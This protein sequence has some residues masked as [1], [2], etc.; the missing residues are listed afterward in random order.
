MFRHLYLLLPVVLSAI[1]LGDELPVSPANGLIRQLQESNFDEVVFAARGSN[2]TDGHWYAN[3]GY[4][5]EDDQ[6]KAYV[7]GSLLA[8]LNIHTG[9]TTVLLQ[10]ATGTIRDP[11][12]DY[13]GKTIVF[14]YRQG[15]TVFFNLYEIQSDGT[16]LRQ[17]TH[18]EYDDIEPCL[19]PDGGIVFVSSRCQRWVN[20]WLTQVAN[21]HRSNRDGSNIRMISANI[22]HDN[23][24]WVLPDGRILH[25]RWEYVDRNQISFHHLWTSN[26]DGTN[27]MVYFGNMHPEGLY[28]DAKPIPGTDRVVMINSPGHGRKDHTGTVAIVTD[29]NGPD[30]LSM[31][32]DIT[33]AND[34]CDPFPVSADLF[35]AARK[36]KMVLLDRDG[37]EETLYQQQ[38]IPAGKDLELAT[39]GLHEPRPLMAR[40]RE[41]MISS[42]VDLGKATG[43]LI[44]TD[45][46]NGRN[47][48]GVEPGSIKELLVVETLPKPINYTGGMDPLTYGGSFTLERIMGTVPV[49][50]DG[51]AFFDLPANRSFFFIAMDEN[52][53]T[54]KR[55][56][57]FTTVMPGEVLSCV[58][59]HEERH[60]T[61]TNTR[62]LNALQ[63]TRRAPSQIEKIQGIPDVF[64][65]PRD[66]QPILDRH[67][68]ECHNPS[69]REGRV[70]LTGDHGPMFSHSYYTLTILGQF[71]DGRNSD[72]VNLSPY[73]IGASASPLMQK[74]DGEHHGVRLT[75]AEKRMVRYWI[76]AGAPYPGTYAALGSGSIGGYYQNKQTENNDMEWAESKAASMSIATRCGSC[77]KGDL[78]LPR[79]LSDENQLSFWKPTLMEP[80]IPRSR[81]IVFNLSHPADSLMLLAPL[82]REAGGYGACRKLN[83]DG[84]FGHLA[85]VFT[86]TSDPDYLAILAM[87]D[88]GR[89]RLGEVKRFDMPGFRPTAAYLREMRRYGILDKT[90]NAETPVPDPYKLDRKYWDSFVYD[91]GHLEGNP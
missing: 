43:T 5:A 55:M 33:E 41:G 49:E 74:L 77:H 88:A 66:I 73:Q 50:E 79:Y 37:N 62:N 80:Q 75:N 57:S 54:V 3:F 29:S 18:G 47:M 82:A 64:D 61:P 7:E 21:L 15:G 89:N 69:R 13:D 22:E 42:R 71:A 81:H 72:Q 16:G 34:Y 90:D 65:Y 20:C 44:L 17:L 45:A 70:L 53:K 26:P 10:D 83:N 59:C 56:R 32:T 30:D 8:K 87:I 84:S 11:V 91:P 63:A 12:V 6:I 31:L 51:S 40:E 14:S 36:N 60:T 25:T 58:G 52:G 35:L 68:V 76:E 19:L 39:V 38:K 4:Y 23:T 46:Y 27:Q 24:P 85:A 9:E 2:P 48:T 78:S 1:L 86:D 28:I 67:C